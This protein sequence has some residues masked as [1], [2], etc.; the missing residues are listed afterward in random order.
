MWLCFFNNLNCGRGSE[1]QE[2]WKSSQQVH[3]VGNKTFPP[4]S[5]YEERMRQLQTDVR[6]F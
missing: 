1:L 6:I 3:I 5:H 2:G 4:G